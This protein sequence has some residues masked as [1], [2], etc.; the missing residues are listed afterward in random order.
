MPDARIN[1][2]AR[3]AIEMADYLI[4]GPGDLYTS[5]IPVIL[6]DGVSAAIKKSKAKIVFIMNLMTKSGQTT[7]YKASDH[8]GDLT[9]YLGRKPD[10]V[11]INNTRISEKILESYKRYNEISVKN[12]LLLRAVTKQVIL[13]MDLIDNSDTFHST[14]N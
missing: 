13:I 3:Q 8:I 1:P 14:T 9:R 12:D 2:K 4:I 10:F 11:L 5:I 7:G 6:A